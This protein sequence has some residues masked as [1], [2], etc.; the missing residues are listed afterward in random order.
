MLAAADAGNLVVWRADDGSVE[1]ELVPLT[2]ERV[3]D[4]TGA[5]DALVA[6]LTAAL[7]RGD[8]PQVATRL[9][10]ARAGATV[11]REGGRTLLTPDVL[12]RPVGGTG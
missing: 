4:T 10:V 9:G 11:T 2:G 12:D 8:P 6:V 3:V 5:G 1:E 7:L